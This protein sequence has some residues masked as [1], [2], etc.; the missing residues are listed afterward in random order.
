[1]LDVDAPGARADR[2]ARQGAADGAVRGGDAAV[3]HAARSRE[4]HRSA[5]SRNWRRARRQSGR[6]E[7][8]PGGRRGRRAAR[9]ARHRRRASAAGSASASA[10]CCA[11]TRGPS[12]TCSRRPA[13]RTDASDT[14]VARAFFHLLA[15]QPRSQER[16]RLA[17]RDAQAH[18]ASPVG[19][20]PARP[21]TTRSPR[22]EPSRRAGCCITLDH[23]GESVTQPGAKRTPRRATTS[24]SST[25]IVASRHRSQHLAEAHAA[26]ASTS[27][28]PARRQ[29]AH[30]C[31]SGR[32]SG[33]FVR[34][35]MESSRYTEVTLD[36]FET[37]WR[38][39]YR[40]I[41]V[42]LQ[43]ALRPQRAGPARE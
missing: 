36:I 17:R 38:H 21:S 33:F 13:A 32:A 24:R 3:D 42:V 27:T 22:R 12:S 4:A 2:R 34:L 9:N 14:R 16:L 26:R 11:T 18:R 8:P 43:A 6:H 10:A 20:S 15:R 31:S 7:R 39:G 28:A 1:M 37:L 35:D 40:Q 5:A 29:P 41:G 25:A 19:S 23:L 30:A